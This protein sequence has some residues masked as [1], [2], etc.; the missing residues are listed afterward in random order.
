MKKNYTLLAVVFFIGTP[1]TQIKIDE[2]PE[3]N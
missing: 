2:A 1:Y 3:K